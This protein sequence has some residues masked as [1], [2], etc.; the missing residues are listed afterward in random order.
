MLPGRRQ[1]LEGIHTHEESIPLF[2]SKHLQGS[3]LRNNL[4]YN[5]IS[6]KKKKAPVIGPCTH[7]MISALRFS[8]SPQHQHKQG[9]TCYHGL[10]TVLV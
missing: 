4:N 10:L 3:L 9:R 1:C 8:A 2:V 7:L 6:K 5:L